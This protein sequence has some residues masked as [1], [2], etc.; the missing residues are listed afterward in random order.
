MHGDNTGPCQGEEGR[1]REEEEEET[2][3]T[4][5]DHSIGGDAE[6]RGPFIHRLD[7]LA[8]LGRQLEVL[9]LAE[10]ALQGRAVLGD[11]VIASAQ[12]LQL[13]REGFQRAVQLALV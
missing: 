9:Q 11:Q 13:T 10:R 12:I 5:V 6:E 7:L 3:A 4:Y 8:A 1:W 2:P